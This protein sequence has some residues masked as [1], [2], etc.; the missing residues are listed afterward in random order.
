[1]TIPLGGPSPGMPGALDGLVGLGANDRVM[2]IAPHPDDESLACAGLLQASARA[3]ARV[4]VVFLTDGDNNPWAQLVAEGRWPRA[5]ADRLR[6]GARRRREAIAALGVLGI[7]S[8]DAVFLGLPDQGLTGLLMR[9]AQEPVSALTAE[10]GTWRPTVVAAPAVCDRHPDHNASAVL[11]RLALL[12]CAL[13]PRL[14]FHYLV[15]APPGEEIDPAPCVWLGPRELDRKRAAVLSHVSQLWWRRREF[16]GFV[17][18][19]ENFNSAAVAR[20]IEERHPVRRAWIE[21]GMLRFELA[22]TRRLAFGRPVLRVVLATEDGD[23][24]ARSVGL[25]RWPRAELAHRS[26]LP[27]RVVRVDIDCRAYGTPGQALRVGDCMAKID[28]PLER[29]LGLFDRW[30][31]RPVPVPCATEVEQGELADGAPATLRTMEVLS[32]P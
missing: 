5:I 4:R 30:G 29:R 26:E 10:L 13:Q 6:W 19:R 8:S 18:E 7:P 2:V 25:P 22:L 31:W 14:T 20:T 9:A 24:I 17:G 23:A 1:M 32:A 15:H 12:R 28:W 16:L 3:A 27:E 21:G 11:L